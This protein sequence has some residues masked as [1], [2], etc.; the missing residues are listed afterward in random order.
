[1]A[2]PVNII[3]DGTAIGIALFGIAAAI[4]CGEYGILFIIILAFWALNAAKG[5]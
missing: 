2:K 3:S 5:K 1:M 4:V